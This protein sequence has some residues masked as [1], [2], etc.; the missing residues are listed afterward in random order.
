LATIKDVARLANTSTATVSRYLNGERVREKNRLS[1]ES[2]IERLQYSIHPI[3][4]GLKTN[5][6]YMIGM[7]VP[8][9][10]DTFFS[11]IAE[12]VQKFLLPH[13]YSLVVLSI[14]YNT[15]NLPDAVRFLIDKSVDGVLISMLGGIHAGHLASLK[16]KRIPVVLLDGRLPDGDETAVMADNVQGAYAALAH[17]IENGHRDIAI[18]N[19]EQ[20]ALSGKERFK[21]YLRALEDYGIEA[22][23]DL[24]KFGDYLKESGYL[25]MR[26]LLLQPKRPTA[27]LVCNDSMTVGAL[28]AINELRVRIFDEL[29]YITFDDSEITRIFN[30]QLTSVRQPL[31]QISLSAGKALLEIIEKGEFR[32]QTI[33]L[34]TELIIRDSVRNIRS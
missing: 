6:S 25:L 27:V 28:Q 11:I 2:A 26:E 31:E 23:P 20:K 9:L 15:D 5:R 32:P 30:P 33:R 17:L 22:D 14:G 29:S 12:N 7:I 21:G 24:I 34:K 3:A 19:G 13:R 4:R 16:E 1:I 10:G 8:Y 18:I